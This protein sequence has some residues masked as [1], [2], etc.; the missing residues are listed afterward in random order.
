MVVQ[1]MAFGHPCLAVGNFANGTVGT[2]YGVLVFDMDRGGRNEG[3]G[4]RR[5][6]PAPGWP[7]ATDRHMS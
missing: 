3:G 1:H 5:R 6:G 7:V 4:R 2:D